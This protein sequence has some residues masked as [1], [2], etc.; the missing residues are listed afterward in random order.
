MPRLKAAEVINP[1]RAFLASLKWEISLRYESHFLVVPR[2]F[3]GF[4]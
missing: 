2:Q 3:S 1:R 4:A